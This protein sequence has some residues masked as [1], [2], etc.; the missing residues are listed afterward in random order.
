M[1]LSFGI[2]CQQEFEQPPDVLARGPVDLLG[3]VPAVVAEGQRRTREKPPPHPTVA[4]VPQNSGR[5]HIKHPPYL[6]LIRHDSTLLEL[7]TIIL[8]N[9]GLNCP[10]SIGAVSPMGLQ[11]AGG[12]FPNLALLGS[13]FCETM[14]N[15]YTDKSEDVPTSSGISIM[16]LAI[17]GPIDIFDNWGAIWTTSGHRPPKRLGSACIHP[18]RIAATD[19]QRGWG[20]HVCTDREWHLI[21][22]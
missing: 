16:R 6:P 8:P 13:V 12:G 14:L 5:N 4:V 21:R 2:F 17:L 3:L 20:P 18:R 19:P 9:C 1:V 22:E 15:E 7:P 10:L 11:I